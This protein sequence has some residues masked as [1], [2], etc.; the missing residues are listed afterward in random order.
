MKQYPSIPSMPQG[1]QEDLF[2]S[3]QRAV[4]D[5]L[6]LRLGKDRVGDLQKQHPVSPPRLS[7][8]DGQVDIAVDGRTP[9]TI[10][11][12]S[13]R[14]GTAGM[15]YIT[16]SRDELSPE[17]LKEINEELNPLG[18]MV[19]STGRDSHM[20]DGSM[21]PKFLQSVA[22]QN[23]RRKRLDLK[24]KVKD[25]GLLLFDACSSHKDTA[26]VKESGPEVNDVCLY[27]LYRFTR[28]V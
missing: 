25:R 16:I 17:K 2:T 7:N 19:V 3:N 18:A 8:L 5:A 26:F 9:R 27:R 1:K 14:D 10:T 21:F 22:A 6:L 11:A 24:L 15:I 4:R 12:W 28:Y 13:W 23:F 20:W